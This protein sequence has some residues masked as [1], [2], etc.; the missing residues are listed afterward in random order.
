MSSK[1]F[2]NRGALKREVV[3]FFQEQ[4]TNSACL[5]VGGVPGVGKSALIDEICAAL[6]DVQFVRVAI[7]AGAARTLQSGSYI[8]KIAAAIDDFSDRV[9]AAESFGTRKRR[10]DGF[11]AVREATLLTADLLITKRIR[12][13][14]VKIGEMVFDREDR[15]KAFALP[16][17]EGTSALAKYVSEVL[18]AI[19]IGVIIENAQDI[20]EYSSDTLKSILTVSPHTKIIFEFT[21]VTE[22]SANALAKYR[23][24]LAIVCPSTHFRLVK[25]LPL[26]YVVQLIPASRSRAREWISR[27]YAS[28]DGNLVPLVDIELSQFDPETADISV[29]EQDLRSKLALLND[30]ELQ[31][32]LYLVVLGGD[33]KTKELVEIHQAVRPGF[34]TLELDAALLRLG[35]LNLIKASSPTDIQ[36]AHDAYAHDHSLQTTFLKSSVLAAS[37]L[38]GYFEAR[39]SEKA[40]TESVIYRLQLLLRTQIYLEDAQGSLRSFS[41]LCDL[42]A[43]ELSPGSFKAM[44]DDVAQVCAVN[45]LIVP[46]QVLGKLRLQLLAICI[47]T[48]V[49]EPCEHLLTEEP[50][51]DAI[52]AIAHALV[53]LGT[54][55]PQKAYETTNGV[56]T[57]GDHS[58]AAIAF[59][60]ILLYVA[61]RHL[62]RVSE[63]R[64]RWADFLSESTSEA[65]S[66]H[67]F[68]LR[69]AE[70][71]VSPRESVP[72]IIASIRTFR[73]IDDRLQEAY[74]LN[75]LGGQLV[76]LGRFR[77]GQAC[78]ENALELI[79]EA[80]TDRGSILNNLA[81]SRIRLEDHL[82]LVSA[83]F[84]EASITTSSAFAR[85]TLANNLANFA[86]ETGDEAGAVR[87]GGMLRR[88]VQSESVNSPQV[89]ETAIL[90][91]SRLAEDLDHPQ[92]ALEQNSSI[93]E[94]D[95]EKDTYK[96]GRPKH[97][98]HRRIYILLTNWYPDLGPLLNEGSAQLK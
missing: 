4:T 77:A 65:S 90:S 73:A 24:E 18:K 80:A 89:N 51:G 98:E 12:E 58:D 20:D 95:A 84:E 78:F 32:L 33:V 46:A 34:F 53:Y 69:N 92:L 83:L 57:Q 5:L 62:G 52:E 82:E 85:L 19:P 14:V 8:R 45:G 86:C 31:L 96:T 42:T 21:I 54:E 88:M 93:F 79:G 3:T 59:A 55:R 50:P 25:K 63:G 6:S 75:A 72:S 71:F 81:V 39:L 64:Q 70:M 9:E 27:S 17:A 94:A 22:S 15:K 68:M 2:V 37:T 35:E 76:R 60:R 48:R 74:S 1:Q 36:I 11:S 91:L 49:F 47:R 97:L 26:E 43:S 30:D 38:R 29:S 41:Q 13:T 40:D 44:L 28:W 87:F 61:L 10:A 66:S 7:S 16:T 23:D 56:L 67:G